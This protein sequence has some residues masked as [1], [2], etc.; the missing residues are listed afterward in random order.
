[1]TRTSIR[2][3]GRLRALVVAA[4]LCVSMFAAA[5]PASAASVNANS[6]RGNADTKAWVW[7]GEDTGFA[8]HGWVWIRGQS[9]QKAWVWIRGQSDQ[10]AWVWIRSKQTDPKAWVWI[11]SKQTDP[12]AWV[13]I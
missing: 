10:K 13:W 12:K 8:P 4:A 11:R 5:L 9:D 2:R 6:L 7:I 3:P 1:M